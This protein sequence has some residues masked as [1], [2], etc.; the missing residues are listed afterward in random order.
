MIK[1]NKIMIP[2]ILSRFKDGEKRYRESSLFNQV[3][4][5]LANDTDP[6]EIIDQ[7]ITNQEELQK[8]FENYINRY[9]K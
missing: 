6:L 8:S 9:S 3:I 2:H 4:N 5:N 1:N 7:L